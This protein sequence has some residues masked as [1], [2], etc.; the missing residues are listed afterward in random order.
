MQLGLRMN[1]SAHDILGIK[2]NASVR[3]I[4]TAYF[5][6]AKQWHP[7]RP[8]GCAVRFNT[9]KLAAQQMQTRNTFRVEESSGETNGWAAA[10]REETPFWGEEWRRQQE[11]YEEHERQREQCSSAQDAEDERIIMFGVKFMIGLIFVRI[12]LFCGVG[13][14]VD[15][16]TSF[17]LQLGIESL[18]ARHHDESQLGREITSNQSAGWDHPSSR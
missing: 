10:D 4:K 9:I 14:L 7:D 16:N 15:P 2:E 8:G 11:R 12:T 13:I 18:E 5:R 6:L 3:D 1:S 17:E